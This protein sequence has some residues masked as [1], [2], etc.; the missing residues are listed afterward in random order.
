MVAVDAVSLPISFIFSFVRSEEDINL[1]CHFANIETRWLG[2]PV[3]TPLGIVS[4]YPYF[5]LLF[6]VLFLPY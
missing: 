4:F 5:S 3:T 1:S 2:M 6:L